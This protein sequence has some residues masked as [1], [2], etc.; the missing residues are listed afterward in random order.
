[1]FQ[2]LCFELSLQETGVLETVPEVCVASLDALASENRARELT[3][4]NEEIMVELV[5]TEEDALEPAAAP[6]GKYPS[7]CSGVLVHLG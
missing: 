1:M 4:A 2:N 6:T 5:H 3:Y 7:F